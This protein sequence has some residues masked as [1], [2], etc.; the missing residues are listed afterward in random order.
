M[1][2]KNIALLFTILAFAS[3]DNLLE[4]V[5]LDVAL[6]P[7]NVYKV[8]EN[9]RFDLFG[10]PNYI[11]FYSGE[12]GFA[13]DNI[14]RNIANDE[15]LKVIL[16]FV[17]KVESRPANNS[18]KVLFS[19][20]FSGI[21]G[22]NFDEDSL[23]IENG[24]W[25]DKTSECNLPTAMNGTATVN[26]DVTE[27]MGKN[28]CIAFKYEAESSSL[29]GQPKWTISNLKIILKYPNGLELSGMKAP[30]MGFMAFDLQNKNNT[31]Y[32][33]SADQGRWNTS[34][35][36][37]SLVM[38]YTQAGAAKNID[39]AISPPLVLNTT[40]PDIGLSISDLR[41]KLASFEYQY[42]FPGTYNVAFVAKN[43]NVYGEK[44][45]VKRVSFTITE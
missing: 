34:S 7:K 8:G 3:C 35:P 25:I 11:T 2:M 44:S 15:G 4:E 20:T 10:N 38:N 1:K 22:T 27:F 12:Q 26:L 24:A 45:V 23:S 43:A 36:Q 9:I 28:T 14:Q 5:D 31:P 30:V 33:S 6:S 19:N 13:Y 40:I 39:Y 42:K 17:A 37:I 18:L 21:K 29:S 16:N 41:D 32:L